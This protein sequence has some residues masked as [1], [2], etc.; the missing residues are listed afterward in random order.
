MEPAAVTGRTRAMT[1]SPGTV[2]RVSGCQS[3]YVA[4]IVRRRAGLAGLV[5]DLV[6]PPI[7]HQ[8][9]HETRKFQDLL[10]I[11]RKAEHLRLVLPQ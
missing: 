8:I 4:S 6:E 5:E 2:G 1:G 9:F 11:G 3:G 7:V 10:A